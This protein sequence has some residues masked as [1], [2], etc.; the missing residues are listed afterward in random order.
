MLW[1]KQGKS[2]R[3]IMIIE[4]IC[5]FSDLQSVYIIM[6]HIVNFNPDMVEFAANPAGYLFILQMFIFFFVLDNPWPQFGIKILILASLPSI[7]QKALHK[8]VV[9]LVFYKDT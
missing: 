7:E 5:Q 3:E 2:R 1:R 9:M 6:Y 4:Q 8:E